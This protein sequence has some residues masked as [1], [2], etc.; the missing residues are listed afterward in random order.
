MPEIYIIIVSILILVNFLS[1]GMGY[2]VGK[3]NSQNI[4][5]SQPKSFF[6][7]NKNQ[8]KEKKEIIKID[9]RKHVIDIKTSGL[10]KKYET[11]GETKKS[12]ENI[13]SSI[14]K[15]KNLKR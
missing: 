14:N 11:L 4:I 8:E 3:L 9:E 2:I 12:E 1:F 6:D 13:E 7:K 5:E 10:E 15:L